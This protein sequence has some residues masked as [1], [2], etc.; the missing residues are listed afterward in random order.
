VSN[1]HDDPVA[2]VGFVTP[3]G[4]FEQSLPEFGIPTVDQLK[5]GDQSRK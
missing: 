2:M 4:L 5:I 3:R 1:I